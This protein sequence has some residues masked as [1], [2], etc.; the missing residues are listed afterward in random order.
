VD[1]VDLDGHMLLAD[2]PF[3]GLGGSKGRLTLTDRPGLG[4][5]E[6]KA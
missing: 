5:V 4:V 1:F 2:D 3:E 6:K